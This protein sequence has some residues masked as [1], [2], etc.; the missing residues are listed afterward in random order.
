MP[1]YVEIRNG[2]APGKYTFYSSII[3]IWFKTSSSQSC[4]IYDCDHRATVTQLMEHSYFTEDGWAVHYEA[5]LAKI[6]E[7][8][9]MPPIRRKRAEE[10]DTT[11]KSRHSEIEKP[12]NLEMKTSIAGAAK[13]WY[14]TNPLLGGKKR[15]AE[16][17]KI[18]L[19]KIINGVSNAY[20]N[21]S[22]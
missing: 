9:A 16:K 5:E 6:L 20:H 17:E 1:W 11:T 21:V 3:G 15:S 10:K 22:T 7:N 12:K 14:T 19:P 8:L 13:K 18:G 4:L 2:M